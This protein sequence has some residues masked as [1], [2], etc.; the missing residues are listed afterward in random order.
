M[1]K[2]RILIVEDELELVKAMQ[3]IFEQQAG[4][5]V[6]VASD[7]QEALD[8]AHN[9]NPDLIILDLMIPKLDGYMVCRML[10]YDRKYEHIPIIM[11][12]ARAQH[13]DEQL[14]W[15]VGADAYIKKPFEPTILL[16]KAED[17]LRRPKQM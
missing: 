16:S 12:T 8:R 9:E 2:K 13:S 7:G 3:V 11:L 6:L 14:G 5:E 10:K 17:L 1:E 15:K 4:Y